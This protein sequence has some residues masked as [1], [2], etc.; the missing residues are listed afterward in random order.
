[1]NTTQSATSGASAD[2]SGSVLTKPEEVQSKPESAASGAER[3]EGTDLVSKLKREKDNYVK[4]VAELQTQLDAQ[5]A[6]NELAKEQDLV[7]KEQFKTLYEREKEKAEKLVQDLSQRDKRDQEALKRASVKEHLVRLGLNSEHEKTAFRL[8]D[9][10]TVIVDQETGA[11]IGSEDAAKAFHDQFKTL[12]LFGRQGVGVSHDAPA[13]SGG[14]NEVRSLKDQKAFD[15][16]MAKK[17]G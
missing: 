10:S 14:V 16:Y 9:I 17:Y 15:A 7:Q 8:M 4:R 1:M 3:V 2:T 13:S 12:G 11:V 5:N 6:A